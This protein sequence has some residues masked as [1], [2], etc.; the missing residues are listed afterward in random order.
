MDLATRLIESGIDVVLDK[1]QLDL[2]HNTIHFMESMV[3]DPDIKKVAIISDRVYVEKANGKLGG[4]GT[5]TQ[6]ISPEVYKSQ[7][8]EKFALVVSEL[9]DQGKPYVPTY[10]K[11]RLHIDL[12]DLGRFDK[13]FERL[14]RWVFGK[15]ENVR[16]PIG[17]P[18]SYID[19]TSTSL[20]TSASASR[21]IAAIEGGKPSASGALKQYMETFAQNLERFGITRIEGRQF[22]DQVVESIRDFQPYKDEA[23]RVFTAVAR[24]RN[25]VGVAD[26]VHGFFESLLPISYPGANGQGSFE[27]GADNFKFIIYQ[28][29][30]SILAVMLKNRRF[31]I[32]AVMVAQQYYVPP[33]NYYI[34]KTMV[35]SQYFYTNFESLETRDRRL[36]GKKFSPAGDL[37]NSL[38]T[39]P[40]D[41]RQI[42]QAEL[43]MFLRNLFEDGYWY[44]HS[45][46][47]AGRSGAFEIFARAQSKANFEKLR[48]FFNGVS[49][50]DFKKAV[51][52][53]AENYSELPR[54]GGSIYAVG[55][56]TD[57]HQLG[58]KP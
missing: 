21:A 18:P 4:V 28:L 53:L 11:A 22:D 8:Q 32:A 46:P 38:A 9:D 39:A 41:M 31:D 26:E 29:Y 10:Y 56:L 58:T 50:E 36:E 30:L 15:P 42:A 48:V 40:I 37:L 54:N 19:E 34:D 20:G 16:P 14:V 27:R 12:T 47:Y 52:E 24:F 44:P 45:W 5:E 13:E 57:A 49:L 3:N 35:G 43:I 6:I 7:T 17:K 51:L 1:W 55:R 2:G 23:I 33:G 25:E